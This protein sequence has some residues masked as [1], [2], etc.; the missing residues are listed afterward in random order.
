[1]S[2]VYVSTPL[3]VERFNTFY[4]LLVGNHTPGDLGYEACGMLVP[5]YGSVFH[6]LSIYVLR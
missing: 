3:T 5:V 6:E 2:S 1:M 4:A